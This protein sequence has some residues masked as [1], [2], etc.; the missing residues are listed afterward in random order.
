MPFSSL[1]FHKWLHVIYFYVFKPL[2][3]KYKPLSK[4]LFL[5]SIS[6]SFKLGAPVITNLLMLFKTPRHFTPLGI[7]HAFPSLCMPFQRSHALL[8]SLVLVC[9]G[10]CN[11]IPWAGWLIE[12]GNLFLITLKAGKSKMKALVIW[13]LL[14]APWFIDGHLLSVSSHSGRDKG[15]LWGPFFFFF[16]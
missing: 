2:T 5:F 3:M 15:T 10:C 12:N 13:C 16:F 7:R 14:R 6:I 1:K 4:Y 11:R 9:W 8:C